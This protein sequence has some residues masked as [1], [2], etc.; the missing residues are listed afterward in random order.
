M[1]L[2]QRGRGRGGRLGGDDPQRVARYAEEMKL[3]QNVYGVAPAG[4]LIGLLSTRSFVA[5][6]VAA[7]ATAADLVELSRAAVVKRGSSRISGQLYMTLLLRAPAEAG[8]VGGGGGG[9]A[10]APG[11]Y[12]FSATDPTDGKET[13]VALRAVGDAEALR[14]IAR[15]YFLPDGRL[16]LREAPGVVTAAGGAG[17]GGKRSPE[18]IVSPTGSVAPIAAALLVPTSQSAPAAQKTFGAEHVTPRPRARSQHTSPTSAGTVTVSCGGGGVVVVVVVVGGGGGGGGG[19]TLGLNTYAN[20]CSRMPR[21]WT[22]RR[23]GAAQSLLTQR[24]PV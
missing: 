23:P 3:L 16:G 21:R 13:A 24:P 20:A 8:A 22:L 17:G 4:A 7:A 5:K 1:A 10:D 9:D 6:K 19:G 14:A 2:L 12:V 18:A 15:V 11:S